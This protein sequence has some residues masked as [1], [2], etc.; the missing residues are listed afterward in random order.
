MYQFG[1]KPDISLRYPFHKMPDKAWD[2]AK[3]EERELR[4]GFDF[5]KAV[6]AEERQEGEKRIAREGR[7][8]IIGA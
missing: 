5:G 6:E 1:G 4:A 7:R 8:I 3:Q 2:Y